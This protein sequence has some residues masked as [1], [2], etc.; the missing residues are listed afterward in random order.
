[1]CLAPGHGGPL[2]LVAEKVSPRIMRIRDLVHMLQT[3]YET[4]AVSWLLFG[5]TAVIDIVAISFLAEYR[6]IYLNTLKT[7]E[8]FRHPLS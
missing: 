3:E 2:L 8:K 6:N 1:M 7:H 4:K 5:L